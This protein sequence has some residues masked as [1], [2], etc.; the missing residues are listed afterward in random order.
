MPTGGA[1]QITFAP[2]INVQ[3]GGQGTE[4]RI[5]QLMDQK[6]REFDSMMK[7]WAANQRRL[8]YE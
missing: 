3:G 6:M 5:S 7:R 4:Q 8:S 1:A 2:T